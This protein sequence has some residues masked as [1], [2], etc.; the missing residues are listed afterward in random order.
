MAN[1]LNAEPRAG[2]GKGSARRLRASGRIPAVIYGHGEKTRS[3]SV[4]G[5]ELDRLFAGIAVESTI[6]N[7]KVQGQRAPVNALVREVQRH[8]FRPEVLHVDFYQVHAG[9]EVSVEIPVRV[10]GTPIG[11]REGGV[12]QQVLHELSISCLPAAIPEAIEIDV[13]ELQVNESLHVS[14]LPLQE[15][16]T[17]QADPEQTV[18]SVVAPTVAVVEEEEAVPEEEAEAEPEVIGREPEEEGEKSSE[19]G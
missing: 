13:S 6:I 7:L 5:H 2:T 10:T 14:D 4:D 12:L 17:I 15:G 9:E 11:V 3:L 16:V 19:E 8:P 18:C 1:Q